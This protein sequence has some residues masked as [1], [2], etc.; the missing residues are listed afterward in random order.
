MYEY[1][2]ELG[3][4]PEDVIW[5]MVLTNMGAVTMMTRLVVNDMKQRKKGVIVN[6]SSGTALQPA[7][8]AS[9]YAASRVRFSIYI[10]WFIK[11]FNLFLL[12]SVRTK[13]TQFHIV[14]G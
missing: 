13:M 10:H 14:V 9:V 6:I 7:P 4:V 1:P 12:E 11:N 5:S 3:K 8:Y 2:E